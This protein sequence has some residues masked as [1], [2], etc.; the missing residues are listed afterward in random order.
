MKPDILSALHIPTAC[1]VDRKL[2]KKQFLENFRLKPDEK[3]LLKSD[4]ESI[5]LVYLLNSQNINIQPVVNSD[6]DYSEVAFIEVRLSNDK[7]Y[8]KIARIIQQIP[9]MVVLVLSF[10]KAFMIHTALK[11][12]NKQDS[13]KLTVTREYFTEW[14]DTG[15][16]GT[17]ER[18]FVESLQIQNQSFADFE[19][20]YR[21]MTDRIIAL[22]L[23]K[24]T[25]QLIQPPQKSNELLDTITTLETEIKELKKRIQKETHFSEK[26]NLNIALK[27]LQDK[28]DEVKGEICKS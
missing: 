7:H 12:I 3:R 23:S 14:I 20:F 15:K 19:H 2:H 27:R 8:K 21:D 24:Y 22:N 4:V 26:V 11:K 5:R 6:V 9:Y 10:H 18:A 28:L 16:M 17:K 1:K 25:E 13:T